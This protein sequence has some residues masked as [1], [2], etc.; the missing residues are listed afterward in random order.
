MS[1]AQLPILQEENRRLRRSVQELEILNELALQIGASFD[2]QGIMETILGRSRRA[3]DAAQ[4]VISLVEE[5]E[6]QHTVVRSVAS[7]ADHAH[8]RPEQKLLGWMF[9]HRRPLR[10]NDPRGADRVEGVDWPNEVRTVLAAPLLVRGHLR[11]ILTVYN[12]RDGRFTG[13]DERLL[14]ILAAQ[15]A[16][17]L[18]NARLLEQEKVLQAV[19]EDLRT[20][21]R[22]QQMLLPAAAPAFEPYQLA[23]RSRSAREVGGDYFDFLAVDEDRLALCLG[24][25]SGKGVPAALLMANLQATIRGRIDGNVT[26]G[27]VVERANRLLVRST[28]SN[29]FVTF[30]FAILDRRT[31][32]LTYCNAGHNPPLLFSGNNEPRTLQEGGAALGVIAGAPYQEGSVSFAP[33]DLLVVYSDGV[34][35]AEDR[36]EQELGVDRLI[37]VVRGDLPEG[38]HQLIET[39]IA[40][41]ERHADGL[42]RHDD[43]TV[44]VAGRALARTPGAEKQHA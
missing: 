30:F 35:E 14:T 9:H 36:E 38:P 8:L 11:G 26:P 32:R 18:E 29:K 15:S 40:A 12:K 16:Q 27:A 24:D 5:E 13:D 4:A 20:A 44:V 25:V 23:G 7:S 34:T 17:V 22:I 10:Q 37:D 2:L 6:T 3:V 19:Q 21:A 33:S 31:H 42:P 39:I 28:G 43:I 1:Q 41:V